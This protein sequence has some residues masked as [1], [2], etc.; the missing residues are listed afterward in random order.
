MGPGASHWLCDIGRIHR[1][2]DLLDTTKLG[3]CVDFM[4]SQRA[5]QL[6]LLV[7]VGNFS[8]HILFKDAEYL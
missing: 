6:C 8:N 5:D 1:C 7:L 3:E 2:E 4:C